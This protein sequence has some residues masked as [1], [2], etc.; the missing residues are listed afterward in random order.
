M[1]VT[2]VII[3]TIKYDLSHDVQTITN[4]FI[5]KTV[6]TN[7]KKRPAVKTVGPDLKRKTTSYFSSAACAAANLAIGTLKG[8]QLT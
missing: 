7:H 6:Y 3:V 4:M 5:C 2:C 8:E 1:T